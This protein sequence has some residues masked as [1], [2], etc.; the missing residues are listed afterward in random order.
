MRKLL[1][2]LLVLIVARAGDAPTLKDLLES[3]GSDME[4]RGSSNTIPVEQ[5]ILRARDEGDY[6]M[7]AEFASHP[8]FGP[9]ILWALGEDRKE[10]AKAL[11]AFAG[12]PA[13]ARAA[14]ALSIGAYRSDGA[15]KALAQLL[16][17]PGLEAPARARVQAALLRAGDPKMLAAAKAALGGKDAEKAADALLLLG[18]ARAAEFLEEALRLASDGT[19]VG[20]D[21]RS[22]F[23][24]VVTTTNEDGWVTQTSSEPRLETLGDVA[25]EA[26]SRMVAP[27]T[28]EQM[29]WW[30][31][32]EHGPRF[33]R[34][35]AGRKLLRQ[36]V[37]EDRK[38]RKEKAV[39]AETALL[40]IARKIRQ[41]MPEEP[42]EMTVLSVAFDKAWTIRYR[43]GEAEAA[44]TVR[45]SG[46]VAR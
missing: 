19:K 10:E 8:R 40:A 7:L 13:S 43:L 16:A 28:P 21:R 34:S 38:A 22:R 26:A 32:V 23:P 24:E 25:L 29:A 11:A 3:Y 20:G 17:D 15:R 45:P 27:T 31:E 1:P 36:W 42:V 46:E 4:G 39:G 37:G 33:P 30:C 2:I 9:E 18:D 14:A 6:G 5:A 44:A 12:L 41:E 35:D